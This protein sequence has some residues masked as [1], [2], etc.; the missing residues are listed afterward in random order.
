MSWYL[1]LSGDHLTCYISIHASP[2]LIRPFFQ[3]VTLGRVNEDLGHLPNMRHFP[4][5]LGSRFSNDCV[6]KKF[7]VDTSSC[8]FF[9]L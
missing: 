1:F 5:K 3:E 6:V 4:W 9:L 8:N 7:G 2:C